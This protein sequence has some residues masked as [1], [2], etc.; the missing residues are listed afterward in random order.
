MNVLLEILKDCITSLAVESSI[1]F[2]LLSVALY[3]TFF[4]TIPLH[5][6]YTINTISSIVYNNRYKNEKAPVQGRRRITIRTAL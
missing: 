3:I 1:S 4:I 2:P 5:R 6:N